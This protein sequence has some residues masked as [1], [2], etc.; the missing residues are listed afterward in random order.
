M[1]ASPFLA[2][3]TFCLSTAAA[4]QS[5]DK[6]L[7]LKLPPSDIPAASATAPA[8]ASTSAN[9]NAAAHAKDP[10]GTFYGDHSGRMTVADETP[11]DHCDDA[12]YNQPQMHGSVETGVVGG[13]HI[14]G[15]SYQA[16][17]VTLS[18]AFGSC[19]H[20]TGGVSISVQGVNNNFN[21]GR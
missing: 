15:G 11:A 3:L 20:P 8:S 13:S 16:G 9:A 17:G 10:P 4:A 14:R 5:T 21:H 12:T 7:N 1:K 6:P 19:D 18:Q 2:A